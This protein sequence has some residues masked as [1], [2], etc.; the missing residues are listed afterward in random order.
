LALRLVSKSGQNAALSRVILALDLAVEPDRD[1]PR[2]FD[3]RI[4]ASSAARLQGATEGLAMTSSGKG[5]QKDPQNQ[6][7]FTALP[8][9]TYRL[10]CVSTGGSDL[11]P[12]PL[13]LLD[14]SVS[15]ARAVEFSIVRSEPIFTPPD[16]DEGLQ[17]SSYDSEIIVRL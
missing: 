14:F 7:T 5:L 15:Q 3:V 6:K 9:G 8:D 16:V 12:G 17:M 1:R 11:A 4:R 2:L 10:L 13:A